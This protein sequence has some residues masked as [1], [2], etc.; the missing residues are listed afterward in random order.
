MDKNTIYKIYERLKHLKH[1]FKQ[2]MISIQYNSNTDKRY[3]HHLNDTEEQ[4]VYKEEQHH[5]ISV[6]FECTLSLQ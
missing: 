4:R 3:K 5:A 1:T 6:Y 2:S